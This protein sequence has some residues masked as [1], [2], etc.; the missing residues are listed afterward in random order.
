M[1]CQ[2]PRILHLAT[3]CFFLADESAKRAR[4]DDSAAHRLG[5]R[6]V[7][8][9]EDPLMRS[10]LVFA[11]VNN[12]LQRQPVPDKAGNCVIT[13]MEAATMSLSDTE[14]VVLSACESGLGVIQVGEGVMGL[15]RA[16]A[17]AGAQTV[18]MTLWEVPD[19]YTKEVIVGFY[20]RALPGV[21]GRSAALR[22]AQLALKEQQPDPYFWGA[23]VCEGDPASLSTN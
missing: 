2:S 6:I 13:A 15:R 22:E 12:W 7:P 5:M 21:V 20:D 8:R 23:F 10:W 11:G 19:R 18:I 3:H 14:L 17:L 16:F 1:K 9:H 4:H